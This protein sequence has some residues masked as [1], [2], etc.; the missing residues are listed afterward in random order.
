M[1]MGVAL[2]AE[3]TVGAGLGTEG[4]EALG[5]E[6][7]ATVVVVA[8][9]LAMPGS[10]GAG[11]MV[12]EVRVGAMAVALGAPVEVTAAGARA[13]VLEAAREAVAT[14]VAMAVAER[15]AVRVA[16]PETAAG[17]VGVVMVVDLE[18]AVVSGEVRAVA[19]TVGVPAEVT[20][21]GV[22]AAA[23]AAEVPAVVVG[24][25]VVVGR[26]LA[27][28]VVLREVAMDL[29][30]L[31]R[32]VAAERAQEILSISPERKRKA[33]APASLWRGRGHSTCCQQDAE[34]ALTEQSC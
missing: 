19:G 24:E 21:A 2:V 32:G 7:R 14:A 1:V 8:M 28:A 34:Q 11:A 5:T 15:V 27:M 25:R 18:A 10:E 13:V 33:K 16:S 6:S 3:A 29:E 17:S 12:E 31:E 23:M 30:T 4:V 20:A 22:T 9:D 26:V